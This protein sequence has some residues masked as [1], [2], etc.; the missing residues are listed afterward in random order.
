LPVESEGPTTTRAEI[1][2]DALAANLAQ[3]RRL[4]GDRAVIGVV[5]ADGY[6]H[7]AVR[8]ARRLQA[9]GVAALAVVTVDEARALREAG[10]EAEILLLGGT[11]DAAE[12]RAC[13]ELALTPV[14]HD[15]AGLE[16]LRAV[17]SAATPI[18]V[19][20][21]V[22]T[23]MHRMGV[24]PDAARALIRDVDAAPECRLAG[25][26]SHYACADDVDLED[27][28][29]QALAFRAILAALAD[30]GVRPPRVHI[31][32]SAGVIAGERLADALPEADTVRPGLMLYGARP[33]LEL[34]G[35]PS[36]E[37]VMTFSADVV[38]VRD[39]AAG[40][41]VGYGATWRAEKATRVATLPI[42][43]ADG[44]PRSLSSAGEV[45]LAG[46]ACPIVGR[47][48][49]DYIGV[50]VG[51]APVAVG[52]RAVLFGRTP[53]GGVQPIEPLAERAGTLA[54]ELMVRVG[55]RVPR[56]EVEGRG[57]RDR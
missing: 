49:M 9:E 50:D 17:G 47:V 19:E 14:V 43:Y 53:E 30:E 12:A 27:A 40:A 44:V 10:L 11:H 52:D 6:G 5:K 1:D 15:A 4:S 34:Y 26:F 32:N 3:V 13:V 33:A 22:D 51:S 25:A 24:A 2:L 16:R 28:R 54:Y 29:A 20:V 48:S 56:I 57:R 36:L 7:G 38:A 37:P 8:I 42:G 21:E 18:A 46:R 31:A 41:S 55:R 35:A 45:W 23:G 39:V